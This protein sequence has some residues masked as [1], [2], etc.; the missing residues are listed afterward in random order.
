M[1][2]HFGIQEFVVFVEVVF[3]KYAVH[4]VPVRLDF[5][6]IDRGDEFLLV[7]EMLEKEMLY[8]VA[9]LAV[10]VRIHRHLAEEIFHV[11]L[12]DDEGSESVP[13]IVKGEQCL[14]SGLPALIFGSHETSS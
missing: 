5:Q 11:R 13:K 3:M 12:F 4:I 8:Q 14:C 9:C 2:A 6:R 1:L 7:F 10:V